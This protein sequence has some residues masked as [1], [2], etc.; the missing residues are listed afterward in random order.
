MDKQ[1]NKI[2]SNTLIDTIGTAS[3][4][5]HRALKLIT[6][7][8]DQVFSILQPPTVDPPQAIPGI[9]PTIGVPASAT[10][11]TNA[12]GA[13]YLKLIWTKVDTKIYEAEI[14]VGAVWANAAFVI[15]T[16]N[17]TVDIPKPSPGTYTFQLRTLNA[18]GV[19][20]AA[21]VTQVIVI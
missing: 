13:T 9:T 20:S 16:R 21:S 14:R 15:R 4:N 10:S 7:Q 5:V 12:I 19:Y 11:F 2:R 1:S 18:N 8:L 17:L 3:P 6:N